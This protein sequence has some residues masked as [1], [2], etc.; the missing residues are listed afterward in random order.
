[1]LNKQFYI[2]LWLRI[3]QA[4]L[5]LFLLHILAVFGPRLPV[6][7]IL[8]VFFSYPFNCFAFLTGQSMMAS[9]FWIMILF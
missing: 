3:R 1:M 8:C 7:F 6:S 5:F 4:G 9:K 2:T